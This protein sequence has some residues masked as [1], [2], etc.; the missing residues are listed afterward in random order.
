MIEKGV[1]AKVIS[2]VDFFG[3]GGASATSGGV[4]GRSAHGSY[5]LSGGA[6]KF[7]FLGQDWFGGRV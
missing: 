5:S 7:M 2:V 4:F 6:T 3:D 1:G